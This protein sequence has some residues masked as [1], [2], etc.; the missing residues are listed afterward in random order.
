[1]KPKIFVDYILW[2][3]WIGLALIALVLIKGI[4]NSELQDIGPLISA[5]A[6]LLSAS[7]ASASVMKNIAETK[8]HDIAKGEKEKQRKKSFVLSV[9]KT[10]HTTTSEFIKKYEPDPTEMTRASLLEN[11]Q[12]VQK[13]FDLIFIDDVLPYLDEKQQDAIGNMYVEYCDFTAKYINTTYEIHEISWPIFALDR[14]NHFKIFSEE[15]IE[16]SKD[17][18]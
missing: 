17:P 18:Q 7:V 12:I 4:N 2:T 8:A 16:A 14:Y 5:L 6:I 13:L 1:M 3:L 10:I 11:N 15:Y 9:M